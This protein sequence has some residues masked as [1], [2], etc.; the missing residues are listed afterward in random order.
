MKK[1]TFIAL[2]VSFLGVNNIPAQELLTFHKAVK[3]AFEHNLQINVAQNNALIAEN[4][5]HPGNAGL[6]PSLNLT[7]VSNQQNG[8]M[9]SDE[10][11]SNLSAKFQASYTL[12]DGFGNIYRFKKLQKESEISRLNSRSLIEQTL[13]KVSSTYYSVASTE[14]NLRIFREL[15]TISRERLQRTIKR[16]QFG[17]SNKVEILAAQVDFNNDSVTVTKAELWFEEAKRNLNALLNRDIRTYFSV[18]PNVEFIQLPE[19]VQLQQTARER[20]AVYQSAKAAIKKAELNK[21][22]A[23]SSQLPRVDLSASYGYTGTSSDFKG[24]FQDPYKTWTVGASLSLPLF[25]GFQTQIQI[26]NAEIEIKSRQFQKNEQ[27]LTLE[28]EVLNSFEAYKNSRKILELNQQN[29]KAAE[30]NFK[31][32][33]ELYYL[34]QVTN[35]QFREAQLNLIQAKNSI[36]EAKYTAKIDQLT[37]L[38]ISGQLIAIIE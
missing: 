26:Q 24:A 5:A 19:L 37:L 35:T 30:L 10:T 9:G 22:I 29:L 1:I 12:F 23:N 4:S 25:N 14:E 15:L 18:D 8:S 36:A 38:Q 28:K 32:T 27:K 16:S 7:G 33:E 6:L 17:Q 31:R 34:G 13:L 21:S 3:L 20:N 2:I 11:V